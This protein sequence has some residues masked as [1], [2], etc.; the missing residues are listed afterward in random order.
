MIVYTGSSGSLGSQ[1]PPGTVPLH[2]RLESPMEEMARELPGLVGAPDAFIHMPGMVPVTACEKAPEL[3]RELNVG[4]SLRWFE[5]AAQNRLP[6]FRAG[7]ERP[8]FR[9]AH[10]P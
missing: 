9:Q 8:Y 6:P 10:R 4:G 5:A 1:M 7:L 3:A 2:T